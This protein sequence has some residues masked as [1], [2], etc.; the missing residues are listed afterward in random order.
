MPRVIPPSPAAREG[1]PHGP[2]GRV[3]RQ[4]PGW[5]ELR[6]CPER[7]AALGLSDARLGLVL[8][9]MALGAL[10]ASPPPGAQ[11]GWA[12]AR[13]PSLLRLAM[14]A[15][16]WIAGPPPMYVLFVALVGIGISRCGDGHRHERQR[17]AYERLSGAR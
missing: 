11:G 12:A 5:A 7:Q 16:L 9:G 3:H 1:P 15:S 17:R 10:V 14:A 8:M 6:R 13:W 2:R 4:R